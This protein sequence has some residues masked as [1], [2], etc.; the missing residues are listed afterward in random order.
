MVA[1]ERNSIIRIERGLS[2]Y[3]AEALPQCSGTGCVIVRL[4]IEES[5]LSAGLGFLGH[6]RFVVR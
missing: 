3:R 6:D 4:I 1:S 5:K 2:S